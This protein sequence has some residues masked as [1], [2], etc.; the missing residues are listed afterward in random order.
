MLLLFVRQKAC[1]RAWTPWT[2][3]IKIMV[4]YEIVK[5]YLFTWIIRGFTFSPNDLWIMI[6]LPLYTWTISS[7]AFSHLYT[8][9]KTTCW[10]FVATISCSALMS[11][12]TSFPAFW[13]RCPLIPERECTFSAAIS[14]LIIRALRTFSYL[15]HLR[16]SSYLIH[17]QTCKSPSTKIVK[18]YI[19]RLN[20]KFYIHYCNIRVKFL[21]EV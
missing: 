14:Y 16:P 12:S 18:L 13:P 11:T 8:L 7:V 15:I 3:L 9:P 10:A 5:G 20:T 21:T 6:M 19:T 1:P 17:V 2:P 4:L